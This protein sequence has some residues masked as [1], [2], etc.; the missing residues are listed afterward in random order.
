MQIKTTHIKPLIL[1][2]CIFCSS[3]SL[4]QKAEKE[5][6]KYE[7]GVIKVRKKKAEII[8]KTTLTNEKIYLP[9]ISATNANIIYESPCSD[10]S[11]MR[12]KWKMKGFPNKSF[13]REYVIDAMEVTDCENVTLIYYINGDTIRVKSKMNFEDTNNQRK[14]TFTYTENEEEKEIFFNYNL[15]FE[16]KVRDFQ[17]DPDNLLVDT[18]SISIVLN[19]VQK[20]VTYALVNGTGTNNHNYFPGICKLAHDTVNQW[21]SDSRDEDGFKHKIIF[22][23]CS[24]IEIQYRNPLKKVKKR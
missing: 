22:R 18:L 20:Y 9:P 11:W 5:K 23:S 12:E 4:S 3:I 16:T 7:R 19:S 14:V 17:P 24:E 1:L 6:K 13:N 21:L 2:L 10:M 8:I 15:N